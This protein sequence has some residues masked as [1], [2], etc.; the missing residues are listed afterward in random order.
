M[1]LIRL[2]YANVLK[3]MQSVTSKW[4]KKKKFIQGAYKLLLFS[5]S[6]HPMTREVYKKLSQLEEMKPYYNFK[7][8]KARAKLKLDGETEPVD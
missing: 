8:S 7:L 1:R 5:R 3:A 2:Q 4:P 6:M